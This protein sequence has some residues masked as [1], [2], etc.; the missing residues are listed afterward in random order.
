M[1]QE[2]ENT[3]GVGLENGIYS[4]AAL[5]LANEQGKAAFCQ[6]KVKDFLIKTWSMKN[7]LTEKNDHPLRVGQR[8]PKHRFTLD[9][10][11][12]QMTAW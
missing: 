1:K 11:T 3:K 10:M 9:L 2:I 4:R 12:K 5:W 7:L 8:F 6:S